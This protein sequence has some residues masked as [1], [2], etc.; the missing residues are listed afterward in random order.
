M[1]LAAG[2]GSGGGSPG[3]ASTVSL[4]QQ[5]QAAVQHVQSHPGESIVATAVTRSV[6]IYRAPAARHPF[7]RLANP[8]SVGAPLVFLVKSRAQG[9][10]HVVDKC[11]S[12]ERF[13]ASAPGPQVM[14]RLGITPAAV[15]EAVRELV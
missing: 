15:V 6:P 2:C 3:V 4:R 13:G 1:L 11:V 14:A 7:K 12:I 5:G 9:W 10:E 8:T